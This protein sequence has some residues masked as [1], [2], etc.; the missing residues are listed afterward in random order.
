MN[1]NNIK[2]NPTNP[3]LI[4]DDKYK[5]LVKSLKDFPEMATVRPVVID[6]N[7][8]IL[9]GNM[10]YKAMIEAGWD[11]IPVKQVKGWTEEQKKEFIVKDNLGYGEWDYDIMANEYDLSQLEDYGMDIPD[12]LRASEQEIEED[13]A[14]EISDEPPISKLGEVYQLGSHRLLCGDATKIED[15]EKLMDGQKADMVFTDPPYGISFESDNGDSIQNDN[16]DIDGM[17]LFN[18]KWQKTAFDASSNGV[19]MMVWQSPRLFHLMDMFGDWKFFRMYSM[20]KSNRISYPHGAWINKTEPCLIFAKGKPKASKENYIDD[21]Y[22]YTHDKE[23]HEDSNV[24]HPTPKPVKMITENL[25]AGCKK[26]SV[27]LDLFGGSGS[28]LIAC[29]QTDRTCYMMELDPRYI[30]VILDR[31]EKFTGQ[32]AIRVEDGKKW[33]DIKRLNN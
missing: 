26:E 10:R 16:L 6:E 27:V 3:R 24:G 17:L 25:K 30:Q 12:D 22:V 1:P 15:V 23:S 14:P 7:N 21:C 5:K 13:E 4:K 33:K 9:G 2:I 31:W 8:V 11:D 20:Y 18:K 19:F 32:D 28:T 29:E